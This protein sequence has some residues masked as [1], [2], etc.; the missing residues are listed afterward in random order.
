MPRLW[1][2]SFYPE[3][4]SEMRMKNLD[5]CSGSRQREEG[6]LIYSDLRPS[7]TVSKLYSPL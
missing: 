1:K 7:G 2:K 3:K 6:E 5:R 4:E